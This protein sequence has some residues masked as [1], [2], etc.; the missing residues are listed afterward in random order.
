MTGT[1]TYEVA[2]VGGGPAGLTAA[3]YAARL[4]HRTAVVDA[5]DGRHKAVARVH[6]LVGV[7]P[8]TS[9]AE[10]AD[11]AVDQLIAYGADYYETRVT[12][13][14]RVDDEPLRF[15]VRADRADLTADRIVLATGFVDESPDVPGLRAFTGRG[16]YYCLHCDA[17]A[18][19]DGRAF[20]LGHDD[21][22]AEVAMILLNVTADVD[23]L[24]DG[25]D[26]AFGEPVAAQLA[27]HPVTVVEQPVDDTVPEEPT[28]G[29]DQLRGLAFADGSVREYRG[30]FAMY[31]RE[32]AND[33]AVD[34]GCELGDDGAVAVD[35]ARRTSVDGVYAAGDLTHGQNQTTIALGDGAYAGIAL[36][37]D[38]RT[39]PVAADELA[40]VPDPPA[41][42]DDLRAR[43]RRVDDRGMH[44]GLAPRPD[45]AHARER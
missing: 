20:V 18:L 22:A 43:M 23:L 15:E 33:L 28:P 11:L 36:H 4:G 35:D 2:V 3:I 21:H 24:L 25:S 16:L 17:Y 9:G 45:S 42:A 7:S 34:L 41:M 37:K 27:A 31:G 40:D 39:F 44:A 10:L 32:Y 12:D 13:I 8:D 38:L 1:P 26:P 5:G 30:G 19:G 14:E 29:D 6:N